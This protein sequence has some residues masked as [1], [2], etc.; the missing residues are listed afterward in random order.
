MDKTSYSF[1][2]TIGQQLREMGLKDIL[3]V[4]DFA[5]AVKD[6]LQGNQ[7]K[8]SFDEANQIL[9][10]L[11]KELERKKSAEAAEKG[12]KAREEGEAFL[13]QNGKKAGVTTTP[14]GLQYEVITEGTGRQPKAT[15]TVRC[16]YHGT[17]I[18]G[19]VF[20][21]SVDRGEP[22]SFGLNQVIAGWTEGVQLM[23]EGAKYRF[24]IPFNLA[25]GERGA[26]ASIPPYSALIF[27]VELLAIV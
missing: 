8:I 12:K 11:F 14:S 21:S 23:K 25:Y 4:D 17:L 20:D 2:L 1:G 22:C 27:E 16:H 19:T 5:D 6:M 26:G 3:Q 18:D 9:D 13:A 15:D 7:C 10:T 24:F